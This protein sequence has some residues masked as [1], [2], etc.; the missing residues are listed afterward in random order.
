MKKVIISTSFFLALVLFFAIAHPYPASADRA[1]V[2]ESDN[3]DTVSDTDARTNE[4][5]PRDDE[6]EIVE[7]TALRVI[8]SSTVSDTDERPA[9]VTDTT[10]T[11]SPL[12]KIEPLQGIV[13]EVPKEMPKG[14]F[15]KKFGQKLVLFFTFD[16]IKDAE[17]KLEYAEENMLLAEFIIEN[18]D[19]KSDQELAAELIDTANKYVQSI[20]EKSQ[21]LLDEGKG[22]EEVKI[23]FENLAIQTIVIGKY[24]RFGG[25]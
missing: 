6:T 25:S 24:K 9:L 8:A 1:P 7:D 21:K 20:T 14:F 12:K 22:S 5:D 19:N 4:T 2:V 13:V 17:K 3:R 18:T 15:W 16:A 10:S 11:T 23:L